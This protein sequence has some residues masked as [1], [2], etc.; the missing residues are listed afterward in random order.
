MLFCF[1]F[2]VR[3][4]LVLPIAKTHNYAN[5]F[6]L[7]DIKFRLAVFSKILMISWCLQSISIVTCIDAFVQRILKYLPVLLGYFALSVPAGL[8]VYWV[9]NNILST[10]TTGGIREYF[11]RNPEQVYQFLPAIP[12]YQFL[13]SV[14]W[15]DLLMFLVDWSLGFVHFCSTIWSFTFYTEFQFIIVCI[16]VLLNVLALFCVRERMFHGL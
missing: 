11:K 16:P 2:D 6:L 8:G 12:A 3:N 13:P 14:V 7:K 4:T 5:T 1:L 10:V 15:R 9:I